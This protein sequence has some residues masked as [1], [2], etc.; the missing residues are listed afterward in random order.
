LPC[1]ADVAKEYG[2]I[3]YNLRARGALIPE[4]DMWIAAIARFHH[5]ILATR[6][7]HFNSVSGLQVEIW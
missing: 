5:L 4:S 3:R 7:N 6:D 1:D 2:L